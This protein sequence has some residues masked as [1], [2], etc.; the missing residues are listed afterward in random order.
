MSY[1][2]TKLISKDRKGGYSNESK[3][4]NYW[5]VFRNCRTE[6]EL[7]SSILPQLH[8]DRF[9]RAKI[10]EQGERRYDIAK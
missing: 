5:S 9:G 6:K 2:K 10:K 8:F 1:F 7:W 4:R 3:P